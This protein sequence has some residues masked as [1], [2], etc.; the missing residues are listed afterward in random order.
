VSDVT[1]VVKVTWYTRRLRAE[2][3]MAKD[4]AVSAAAAFWRLRYRSSGHNSL[5]WPA[6][7]QFYSV[8]HTSIAAVFASSIIRSSATPK[9]PPHLTIVLLHY[10][11]KQKHG[12]RNLS[13]AYSGSKPKNLQAYNK[14]IFADSG[15]SAVGRW[16]CDLQV[17]GSIPGRWLSLNIGQ[18]SLASLRGR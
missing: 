15:G 3:L 18:L 12:N 16:T 5:H 1:S 13:L 9:F 10:L 14:R 2:E 6:T 17:A 4:K 8:P 7:R 11:A